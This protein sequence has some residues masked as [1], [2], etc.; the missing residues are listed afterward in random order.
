MNTWPP[1]GISQNRRTR[2]EAAFTLAEVVVA[3]A[4]AAMTV[5][6]VIQ[7]HLQSQQRADWSGSSLAAQALAVQRLEQTRAA[8]WDTEAGV[9]QVITNNF[10][11]QVLT[12][13]L[14]MSGTNIVYATNFTTITTISATAPMLKMIRVDCVW[15]W[16]RTSRVTTNTVATYRAP[17]NT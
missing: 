14:P 5:A 1:S 9:D 2:S 4:I 13:D 12:L 7:G 15:R 16:N 3:A 17:D 6:G 11:A 10:P 8:R